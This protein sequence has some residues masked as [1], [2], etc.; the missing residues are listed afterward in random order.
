[1][2]FAVTCID[3]PGHAGVRT[4]NRAAHLDF[5][6]ANA[7]AVKIAGPFTSDDGSAMVGSL[8]VV[9]AADRAALDA[10]LAADPYAAAGLFERVEIRPWRWVIGNPG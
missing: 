4:E 2:L 6:K 5:L 10:L 3:K 1:M 7:D 8:L 9:E